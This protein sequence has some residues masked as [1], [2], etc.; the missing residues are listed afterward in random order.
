MIQT[1]ELTKAYKSSV[2]PDFDRQILTF[3]FGI[4]V[5][6]FLQQCQ[7]FFFFFSFFFTF[8]DFFFFFFLPAKSLGV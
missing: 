4:Y 5:V 3:G 7:A 6:T 2:S 1:V 8:L